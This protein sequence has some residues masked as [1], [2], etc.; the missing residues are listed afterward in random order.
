[1]KLMAEQL[2]A[3]KSTE[4]EKNKFTLFRANAINNIG[5]GFSQ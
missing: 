4:K 2:L 1:M 5:Y 3:T